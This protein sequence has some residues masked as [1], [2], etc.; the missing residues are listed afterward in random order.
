MNKKQG[1]T[2]ASASGAALFVVILVVSVVLALLT[3]LNSFAR[4][5]IAVVVGITAA[6]ATHVAVE[7]RRASK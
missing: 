2:A 6:A 3:D 7:R 4:C 1:I 5:G